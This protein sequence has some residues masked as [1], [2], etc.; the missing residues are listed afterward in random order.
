LVFRRLALDGSKV[1]ANASKH[2]AM[3]YGWMQ[4]SVAELEE[5]VKRLL[6]EAEKMDEVEDQRY[7]KG[8]GGDE[9]PEEP[10]ETLGDEESEEAGETGRDAPGRDEEED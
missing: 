9:L 4:K 6:G 1:K 3:S 7:G 5:E 2:K 8:Q 10:E